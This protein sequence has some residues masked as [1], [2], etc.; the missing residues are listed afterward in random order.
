M[1]GAQDVERELSSS[2]SEGEATGSTQRKKQRKS[3]PEPAELETQFPESVS[4]DREQLLMAGK[5]VKAQQKD[6]VT[7]HLESFDVKNRAWQCEAIPKLELLHERE[8]FSSGAFRMHSKGLQK[9][10][11]SG[12]CM[13]LKCTM[14]KLCG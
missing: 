6:R 7:L 12:K 11:V 1:L 9:L 10:T 13:L 8:K 4:I 5:L 2:Y 14:K 3:S